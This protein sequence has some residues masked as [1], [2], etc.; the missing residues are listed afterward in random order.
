MASKEDSTGG[1]TPSKGEAVRARAE[2]GGVRSSVDPCRTSGSDNPRG[3]EG[4]PLVP[5][6]RSAGKD[7][8]TALQRLPAPKIVRQL[9]LTLCREARLRDKGTRK[10]GCGKTARP[11]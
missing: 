3:S 5:Q 7:V 1:T 6:E 9:Q 4:T 8:V 10:A 2:V 11:V